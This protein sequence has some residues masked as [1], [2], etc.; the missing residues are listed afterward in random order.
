MEVVIN[1]DE[2]ITGVGGYFENSNNVIFK[3]NQLLT[4]KTCGVYVYNSD[5]FVQD[6]LY[7]IE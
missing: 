5:V 3:S 6:N 2:C 1:P 4:I 7:Q